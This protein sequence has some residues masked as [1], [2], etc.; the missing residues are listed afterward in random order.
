MDMSEAI[1]SSCIID[2]LLEYSRR[3]LTIGRY[4]NSISSSGDT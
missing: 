4:E 3:I 1:V 2:S